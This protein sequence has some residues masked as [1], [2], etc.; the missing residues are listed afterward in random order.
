LAV[1][2][3]AAGFGGFDGGGFGGSGGFG[4]FDGG[5]FG[6]FGGFGGGCFGG[7]GALGGF[8]GFGWGWVGGAGLWVGCVVT[9]AGRR[10][11]CGRRTATSITM[12][13]GVTV[14]ATVMILGTVTVC[15][16]GACAVA[17]VV[18]VT[19]STCRTCAA[20]LPPALTPSSRPTA[21]HASDPNTATANRVE[22][23]P[24]AISSRRPCLATRP[25]TLTR[26]LDRLPLSRKKG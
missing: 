8:A 4:G 17:R 14:V 9:G 2:E 20:W 7:L 16:M 25:R 1:V 6:G 18:V 11:D 22:L 13:G 5:G 3:A 10:P 15:V 26:D 12:G 21:K 19:V 23:T 24:I